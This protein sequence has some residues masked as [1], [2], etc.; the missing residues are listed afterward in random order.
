MGRKNNIFIQISI[1]KIKYIDKCTGSAFV[2]P[3]IIS[4]WFINIILYVK[5]DFIHPYI[6]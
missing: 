6:N 2:D 1:R 4:K 3:Q 5:P